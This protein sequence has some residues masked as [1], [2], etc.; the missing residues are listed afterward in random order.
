MEHVHLRD[1]FHHSSCI[2]VLRSF[3]RRSVCSLWKVAVSLAGRVVV[4]VVVDAAAAAV[5]D[6]TMAVVLSCLAFLACCFC[7][8]RAK[9]VYFAAHTNT[10]NSLRSSSKSQEAT[11]LRWR[12]VRSIRAENTER[13]EENIAFDDVSS[14]ARHGT[15]ALC[16]AEQAVEK[17]KTYTTASG[18]ISTS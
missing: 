16:I 13:S 11:T 15:L 9:C 18:V 2:P 5:A 12:R 4:V 6:A 8:T 10:S 7:K 17:R 1:W 3:F 14:A